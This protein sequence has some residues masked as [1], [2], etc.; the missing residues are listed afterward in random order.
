MIRAI[1]TLKNQEV[2]IHI[3]ENYAGRK[4]EVLLYPVNELI[5]MQPIKKL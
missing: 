2:S 4:M 5:K 3:P 1:V